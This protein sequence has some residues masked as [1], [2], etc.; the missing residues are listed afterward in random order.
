MPYRYYNV[1]Y[2]KYLFFEETVDLRLKGDAIVGGVGPDSCQGWTRQPLI[3]GP[4]DGGGTI[5]NGQLRTWYYDFDGDG[6][7]SETYESGF[8]PKIFGYNYQRYW[9][10][11]T[12]GPDC[13]DQ[14]YDVSN[15]NCSEC[16]S[17]CAASKNL[18][19]NS[20]TLSDGTNCACGVAGLNENER[21]FYF[22]DSGTP[23]I[24]P[25]T[26]LKCFDT[27]KP[28]KITIYVEQPIPKSRDIT[29]KIGH[30]FIGIEQDGIIRTLGFYPNSA[31]STLVGGTQKAEIHDN[32]GSLFHVSVSTTVIASTL[33]QILDR[34]E[35]FPASYDLN[36]YNC[37]DFAIEIGR[38]A[39]LNIPS[40]T[41]TYK[42]VIFSFRGR[43]PADLGEDLRILSGGFTTRNTTG[44]NA[45]AGKGGC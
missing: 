19:T 37:A 7:H 5:L 17:L 21:P 8:A 43:N 1:A 26:E 20:K 44:G 34:I 12:L 40:T 11:T 28:A 2:V 3:D 9:K 24:K 27:S 4:S 13:D 16:S 38:L 14:M 36:N 32:S 29:A 31:F 41:G 45:P 42:N 35:N 39:R 25:K 6:F 23:K 10:T 18:N 33:V 30:A 22:E 15:R